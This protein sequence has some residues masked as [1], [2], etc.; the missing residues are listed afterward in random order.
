MNKKLARE[1][2]LRKGKQFFERQ[3][4]R[5]ESQ[6]VCTIT[7]ALDALHTADRKILSKDK[8]R[9]LPTFEFVGVNDPG[10]MMCCR[11]R[12]QPYEGKLCVQAV[13]A[14][15]VACRKVHA[16]MAKN[17]ERTKLGSEVYQAYVTVRISRAPCSNCW[18]ELDRLL[19]WMREHFANPPRYTFTLLDK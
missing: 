13:H 1:N 2:L 17:F 4:F 10:D 7:I 12:P 14:E 6:T 3:P 19:D 18:K 9:N 8:D 15:I 5:C 16:F 11:L